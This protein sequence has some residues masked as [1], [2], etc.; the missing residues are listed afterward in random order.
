MKLY[1]FSPAPAAPLPECLGLSCHRQRFL[2]LPSQSY[3][4]TPQQWPAELKKLENVENFKCIISDHFTFLRD[5]LA[6]LGTS[7]KQ[8]KLQ[9]S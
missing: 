2:Q 3:E 1:Q 8:L 6:W 9:P 7:K 4:A 5:D